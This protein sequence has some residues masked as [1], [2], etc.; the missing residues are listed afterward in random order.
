MVMAVAALLLVGVTVAGVIAGGSGSGSASG[1]TGVRGRV[2]HNGT[3]SASRRTAADKPPKV[4]VPNVVGDQRDTALADLRAHKLH[5]WFVAH[6]ANAVSLICADAA[7]TS[8]VIRQ[9]PKRNAHVHEGARV[10]LAASSYVQTGC[11]PSTASRACDP[12][13]LSL[14]VV[15]GMPDYTGGSED[16]L[17]TVKVKHARGRGPCAVNSPL[18]LAIDQP[19]GQAASRVFG[20]PGTLQLHAGLH[21][22]ELMVAG[23]T[24]GS[25]CGSRHGVVA[26]ATFAGLSAS[27]PLKQ[28]PDASQPCPGLNMFE[29][30]RHGPG[31]G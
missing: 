3:H 12:G 29:L 13:E 27:A 31:P 11:G 7:P 18:E 4:A 30:F 5:G 8:H 28:L 22:G 6:G 2:A 17:V 21:V 16:T 14:H 15:E 24:L 10:G 20:N 23:W 1:P 19:Q 26:M 25:W 9:L